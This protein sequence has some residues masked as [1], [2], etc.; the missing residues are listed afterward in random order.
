MDGFYEPLDDIKDQFTSLKASNNLFCVDFADVKSIK[1]PLASV[2]SDSKLIMM[3]NQA[4]LKLDTKF[5]VNR[6]AHILSL[7]W[8]GQPI[9]KVNAQL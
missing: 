9:V 7:T 4:K 6:R 1:L 5:R 8:A 2:S 3:H